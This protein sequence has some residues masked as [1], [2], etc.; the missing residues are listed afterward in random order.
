MNSS[1]III[2]NK[3]FNTPHFDQPIYLPDSIKIINGNKVLNTPHFIQIVYLP[4]STK[5]INGNEGDKL[6]L[7]EIPTTVT[8][9]DEE[10][11][12]GCFELKEV[13]IPSTITNIPHN[14]F[15]K[16]PMLEEITIRSN[17][18]EMKGNRI[19]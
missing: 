11:F 13:I 9:I 16:L 7:L 14:M 18:N 6:T 2:R 15:M 17:K 1:Q 10:C 8:S 19:P 4:D 12:Y 5:I 3:I